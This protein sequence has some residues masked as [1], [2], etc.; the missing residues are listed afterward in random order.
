MKYFVSISLVFFLGCNKTDYYNHLKKLESKIK[1][2]DHRNWELKFNR[3]T[4]NDI[5][6]RFIRQDSNR[7]EK[8]HFVYYKKLDKYEIIDYKIKYS[9]SI[10]H[11]FI[12]MNFDTLYH[13]RINKDSEEKEFISGKYYWLFEQGEFDRNQMDFFV[14]NFDSLV[15]VKG[16]SIRFLPK[17][18]SN[19]GYH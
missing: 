16:D 12:K 3:E 18:D 10:Y 5:D 15:K 8:I 6:L 11:Y 19:A 2:F 14:N 1:N 4:K 7:E 17:K 9:D 13:Y